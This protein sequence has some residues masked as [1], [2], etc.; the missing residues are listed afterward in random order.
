MY[1]NLIEIVH[2]TDLEIIHLPDYLFNLHDIIANQLSSL[3]LLHR[4]F[5]KV[6]RILKHL[7]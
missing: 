4:N 7:L 5:D 3:V 1:Y 2:K 6:K